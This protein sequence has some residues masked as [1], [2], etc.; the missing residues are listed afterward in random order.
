MLLTIQGP[1]AIITIAGAE[2][3]GKSSFLNRVLLK[4]KYGFLVGET[5]NACTKG[6][7]IWSKV[8]QGT[9]EGR[10]I[11]ILVCDTEGLN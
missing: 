1:I 8:I 5:K 4:Q 11:N 3:I 2:K 6:I 10:P 9:Y 7:W